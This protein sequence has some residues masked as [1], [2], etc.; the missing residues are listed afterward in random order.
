L[1]ALNHSSFDLVLMDIQM[2]V[3]DGIE[4]TLAIR[5]SEEGTMTHQTIIALTAHAMKGDQERCMEAGMDG[6]LAKPIRTEEL[7]Q[8][9]Q[10]VQGQHVQEKFAR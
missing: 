4:A 3:M 5:K 8:V 10:G 7:D 2:P 1:Q 6:Y 9:L